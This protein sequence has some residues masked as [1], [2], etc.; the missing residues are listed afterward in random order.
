MT[1]KDLNNFKAKIGKLE[2]WVTT[3]NE[4]EVWVKHFDFKHTLPKYSLMVNSGLDFCLFVYGW[5][6]P[7]IH[8]LYRNSKHSIRYNKRN[9]KSA[10]VTFLANCFGS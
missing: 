1:Y 5:S 9:F 10:Y 8:H 2:G 3:V 4:E 6:L 7:D